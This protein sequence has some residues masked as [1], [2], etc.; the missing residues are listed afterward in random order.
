MLPQAVGMED[1]LMVWVMGHFQGEA[2]YME[3]LS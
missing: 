1:F 2:G 3:Y